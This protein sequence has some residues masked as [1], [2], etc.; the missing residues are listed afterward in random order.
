MV[1]DHGQMSSTPVNINDLPMLR[2]VLQMTVSRLQRGRRSPGH[3]GMAKLLFHAI[4]QKENDVANAAT[5]NSCWQHTPLYRS[6][7]D[8]LKHHWGTR[9]INTMKKKSTLIYEVLG[10][11]CSTFPPVL[12]VTYRKVICGQI[13]MLISLNQTE[14][15]FLKRKVFKRKSY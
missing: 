12:G 8:S 3:V 2:T 6:Q 14:D 9:R 4:M 13:S 10:I 5:Q 15:E 7:E 1:S 11:F